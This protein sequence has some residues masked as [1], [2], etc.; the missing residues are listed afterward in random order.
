MLLS[1]IM[2]LYNHHALAQDLEIILDDTKTED[3]ELQQRLQSSEG[4]KEIVRQQ[5]IR[6]K[7]ELTRAEETV[8]REQQTVEEL[9]QQIRELEIKQQVHVILGLWFE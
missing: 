3:T 2:D 9:Q 8:R 5:L 4:E 1:N 6:K 7:A